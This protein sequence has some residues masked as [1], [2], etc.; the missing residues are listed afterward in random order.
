MLCRYS[1]ALEDYKVSNRLK[2]SKETK[3]KIGELQKLIYKIKFEEAISYDKKPE[4]E[5][6]NLDQ[7]G[8]L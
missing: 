4:S 6:I 5:T 7:Y 3:T 1:D 2:P 8:F